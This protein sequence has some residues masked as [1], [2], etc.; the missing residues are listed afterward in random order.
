MFRTVPGIGEGFNGCWSWLPNILNFTW[1]AGLGGAYHHR[2]LQKIKR[3][4]KEA[5]VPCPHASCLEPGFNPQL[6]DSWNFPWALLNF[7]P[8]RTTSTDLS[9]DANYPQERTWRDRLTPFVRSSWG[10]TLGPSLAHRSAIA[11]SMGEIPGESVFNKTVLLLHKWFVL[12]FLGRTMTNQSFVLAV[13]K[14]S[15]KCVAFL[16]HF[17]VLILFPGFMTLL[18]LLPLYSHS[19]DNIVYPVEQGIFLYTSPVPFW[20]KTRMNVF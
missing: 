20:D 11:A 15:V 5:T 2:F 18:F 1:P 7:T 14:F 4:D 9:F 3:T 13:K 16:K 17:H 19:L 10:I 8:C 6:F 12:F